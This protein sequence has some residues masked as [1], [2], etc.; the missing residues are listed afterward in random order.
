MRGLNIKSREGGA[1]P[2]ALNQKAAKCR[3]I[4]E[5]MGSEWKS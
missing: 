3:R 2:E 5:R 1:S 4:S